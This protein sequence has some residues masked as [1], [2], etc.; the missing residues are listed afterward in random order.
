MYYAS[1]LDLWLKCPVRFSGVY[2]VS[3][4]FLLMG[5]LEYTNAS[6]SL[7]S[8]IRF[9]MPSWHNTYY[10]QVIQ[11]PLLLIYDHR[12]F[13]CYSLLCPFLNTIVFDFLEMENKHAFC[14]STGYLQGSN[15]TASPE[16]PAW[17]KV[18]YTSHEQRSYA[19]NTLIPAWANYQKK[20]MNVQTITFFIEAAFPCSFWLVT[21]ILAK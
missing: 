18:S 6:K 15:S 13:Y 19:A 14:T 11:D 12:Y 21:C 9:I 2:L 4:H 5:Q 3:L 20:K 1:R 16:N 10:K 7:C 17:Q 8:C